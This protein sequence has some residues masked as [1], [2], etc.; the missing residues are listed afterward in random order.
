M[1]K[2]Y[3][4]LKLLPKRPAF[5]HG[6]TPEERAIMQE[7]VA[8]WNDLMAK[9]TAIVFGPVLDPR[10]VYGINIVAA[11]DA[12]EVKTLIAADPAIK[13]NTYEFHQMLAVVK[14]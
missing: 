4:A 2:K 8:Y 9:G 1:A 11:E 7:H 10:G 14:S 13:I 3:F 5:A 12:E 6:M